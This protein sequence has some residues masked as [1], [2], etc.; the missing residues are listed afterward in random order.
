MSD[1]VEAFEIIQAQLVESM[2]TKVEVDTN[3]VLVFIVHSAKT[4]YLWRGKNAGITEK[5]MGTR[6]AAKLSHNYPSYRIRP[7]SEG[8]EPAAFLHMI[9]EPLR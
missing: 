5:L 8:S 9:G 2:S 3:K 4:I 7:I 1:M 6:V